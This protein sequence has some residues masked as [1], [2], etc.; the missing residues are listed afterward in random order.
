MAL[1]SLMAAPL[2]MSTD[3]D[4]IRWGRGGRGGVERGEEGRKGGFNGGGGGER[5]KSGRRKSR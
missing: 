4:H 3:L 1:W 2:L 5:S